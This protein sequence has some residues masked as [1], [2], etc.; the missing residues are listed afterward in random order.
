MAMSR[1]A[2]KLFLKTCSPF[3]ERCWE[4]FHPSV[5]SKSS[6]YGPKISPFSIEFGN[7]AKFEN[8]I[9]FVSKFNLKVFESRLR[10]NERRNNN[11]RCMKEDMQN[12]K[13]SLQL[14]LEGAGGGRNGSSQKEISRLFKALFVY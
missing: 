2:Y 8:T 1:R 11:G 5:R 13:C 4:N 7:T 12:P 9:N 6:G 14:I 10:P 3:P